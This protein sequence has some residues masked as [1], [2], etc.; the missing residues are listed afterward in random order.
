M[1][2]S[3]RYRYPLLWA[4][5]T[6]LVGCAQVP[7]P[8]ETEIA[9]RRSA[10]D[11]QVS[12]AIAR[13][14]EQALRY[15]QSGDLAASFIQ[16]QIVVLLD[17]RDEAARR[18][19]AS[20]QATITR[21]VQ[22]NYNAGVTALRN[23]D[24]DRAADMMLKVLALEPD[25][26][27]AAKVLRDIEKRR[28]SKIQAG[29]AARVGANAAANGQANPAPRGPSV[30]PSDG[31][32]LGQPLE[33]FKAGDTEGGLRDLKRYVDANPNDRAG[34]VKIGGVVYDRALETEQKGSKEQA[35]LFF[36]QAVALRGDAAPGWS[37]HI[38][39][40]R[41]AL[42]DDYYQKGIV[43]FPTDPAK[44]IKLWE[45]SLRYDPQNAKAAAR[46][47]DARPAQ[48]KAKKG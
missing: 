48:D 46:L 14:R 38:L 44:A 15:K 4:G 17:P 20:T 13:H 32:D 19:L 47:K 24:T 36:D 26:A 31:Y 5:I 43:L 25:N 7:A 33:M 1:N 28:L 22:E 41:K 3:A 34:R 40:L 27:D 21:R 6:L 23:N 18:E 39:G 16:W 35:L 29:R 45:T 2:R 42:S 8:P 30:A 10:H 9:P 11:E 37:A 12:E